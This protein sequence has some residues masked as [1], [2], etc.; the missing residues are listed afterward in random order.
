VTRDVPA[1]AASDPAPPALAV[2]A[3][4]V[5]YGDFQVLWDVSLR[6]GTGE[7]VALLGPNGAGKSTVLNA[8]SGL[9][10]SQRGQIELFG[11]RVDG[12]PAHQR[13]GQ[14]L[15][16][17]LERRR[18]FPALTVRQ[19]LLLGAYHERA[20]RRRAETLA[21]VE[22]LFPVL[23]ARASQPAHTLS[24][25]EQQMVAIARGLMSGPRLLMIDEPTL[26]LAP[27][28]AGQILDVLGRLCR[29]TGL[30]ILFIEQNA[31]LA[32]SLAH[33]G[34]V[35]ESGRV[36]LDGPSATLLGSDEVKRVFLGG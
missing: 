28:V 10:P 23:H 2:E 31:E 27:R 21:W 16:H 29:E 6:V 14:G 35:L 1:R 32:L 3:L 17:V 18:L 11:Q 20:R 12:L 5:A 22:S 4:D 9:V 19:N 13:V 33:R 25:G 8:V 30:T 24:G 36:L 26:G 7:I 15:A 34:Y